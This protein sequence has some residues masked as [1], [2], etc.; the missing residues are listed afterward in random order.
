MS[1]LDALINMHLNRVPYLWSMVYELII[2]LPVNQS[3]L[4][5]CNI[6]LLVFNTSVHVYILFFTPLR[7]FQGPFTALVGGLCQTAYGAVY[8]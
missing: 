8:K 6:P 7:D 1:S 3:K 5:N 4:R 2:P